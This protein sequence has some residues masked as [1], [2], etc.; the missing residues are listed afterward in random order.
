[1][2]HKFL[3]GAGY[4]EFSHSA[5]WFS[6]LWYKN[7]SRLK[8]ERIVVMAIGGAVPPFTYSHRHP[9]DP[10]L[11]LI[12]LNNNLGHIHDILGKSATPKPYEFC[13]WSASVMALAMIAYNDCSDFV[14]HE[15]DCLSFGPVIE[16]MYEECG[17]HGMIFGRKMQSAPWMPCAQSL[18]LIKHFWIPDFVRFY[19]NCGSDRDVNMLPEHKF[20]EL[21]KMFPL[22]VKQFSFGYDR[23]RPVQFTDRVWY[24]QKFTKQE[25]LALRHRGFI[26]FDGDVPDGL[27]TS[28]P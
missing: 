28:T 14:Y 6:T 15:A 2:K 4:Y 21:M 27:F 7:V 26:S 23:E 22:L 1:M 16:R 9:L 17:D 8:A 13:G 19:L 18:F 10:P 12:D 5:R 24:G 20:M 3:I 11:T 25:L